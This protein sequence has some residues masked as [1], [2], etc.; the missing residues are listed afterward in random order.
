MRQKTRWLAPAC[1]A[2]RA[3]PV[4]T[5]RPCPS[6]PVENSTPGTWWLM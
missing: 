3:I 2:A 1:L 6:E 5:G 4:A